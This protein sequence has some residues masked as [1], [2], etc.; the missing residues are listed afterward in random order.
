MHALRGFVSQTSRGYSPISVSVRCRLE[1]CCPLFEASSSCFAPA[2]DFFS[3]ATL[4]A[5]YPCPFLQ[6]TSLLVFSYLFSVVAIIYKRLLCHD[7]LLISFLHVSS[8]LSA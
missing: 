7:A 5:F 1:G 6:V 3:L 4:C 2:S 8:F